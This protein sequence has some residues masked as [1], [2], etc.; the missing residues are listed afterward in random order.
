MYTYIYIYI[1]ITLSLS[2]YIYIYVYIYIYAYMCIIVRY[3]LIMAESSLPHPICFRLGLGN[4][5][6]MSTPSES[7]MKS[8]V[9]GNI[10]YRD[11]PYE[12]KPLIKANPLLWDFPY[13]G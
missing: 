5:E 2:I 10:S 3:W 8:L 13:K 12:G 9:K 6:E 7:N 11:I 4:T 1:Y